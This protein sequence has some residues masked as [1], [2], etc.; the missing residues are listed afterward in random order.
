MKPSYEK[1]DKNKN[2]SFKVIEH[3]NQQEYRPYHFHPE[4]EIVIITRGEGKRFVGDHIG[5]FKKND[6]VLVGE[7]LP[8]CWIQNNEI[9]AVVIQF[10]KEL[11]FDRI[12]D[13]VEFKEVT[14]LLSQADNGVF[15]GELSDSLKKKLKKILELEGFERF[16][17]LLQ[18]LN[19]LAHSSKFEVLS[20][21]SFKNQQLLKRRIDKVL[22]YIYQNMSN[23]LDVNVAAE[24]LNMNVSAFCHY[25]KKSTNRTFSSFVN[26]IRIGYAG[27]LLIETDKNVSEIAFESGYNSLSNFN[28]RFRELKGISP[29]E[30]RKK[31]VI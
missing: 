13:L 5:F 16:I 22:N 14:R 26:Q 18:I 20:S 12:G 15:F 9:D 21:F 27:K 3:K 24:I 30:Y 11:F 8:H 25:F 6:L 28:K 4:F 7:N 10:S 23:E 2:S 29:N 31:Y 19:D 17:C 1:I